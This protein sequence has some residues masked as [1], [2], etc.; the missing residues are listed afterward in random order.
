M[1]DP[2]NPAG[3]AMMSLWEPTPEEIERLNAG[4]PVSLLVIGTVH[5]PVSIGVGM[6]PKE[7]DRDPH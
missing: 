6:A 1:T 5:P 2:T 3:P 7:E 4:A